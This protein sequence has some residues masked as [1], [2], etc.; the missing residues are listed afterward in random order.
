MFLLAGTRASRVYLK[1]LPGKLED[2]GVLLS[3]KLVMSGCW[4]ELQAVLRGLNHAQPP[5]LIYPSWI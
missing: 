1:V 5:G 4:P 3:L 2:E